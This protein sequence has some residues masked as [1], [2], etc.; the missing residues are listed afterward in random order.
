MNESDIVCVAT[1]PI[2]A[3]AHAWRNA[4][5]A[6]GIECQV[7]EYLTFWF[8]NTPWAQADVW[9]HRTNAYRARAIL[10]QQAAADP[11]L[12]EPAGVY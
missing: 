11:S 7:G 3:R 4:L 12:L 2:Q 5:E 10:E 1:T 9:V 8:D 6:E